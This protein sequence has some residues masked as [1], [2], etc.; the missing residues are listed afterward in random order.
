MPLYIWIWH[1]L[2][3]QQ[4]GVGGGGGAFDVRLQ[5]TTSRCMGSNLSLP[6][7]VFLMF[8]NGQYLYRSYM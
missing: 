4:G 1:C 2:L 8:A 5:N 7:A 3:A 6:Q